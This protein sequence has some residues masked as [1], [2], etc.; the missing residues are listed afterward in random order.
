MKSN[1]RVDLSRILSDQV[2]KDF[3][4]RPCKKTYAGDFPR[5]PFLRAR[6]TFFSSKSWIEIMSFCTTGFRAWTGKNDDENPQKKCINIHWKSS[7]RARDPSRSGQFRQL[8]PGFPKHNYSGKCM[9]I[10]PADIDIFN[11][12]CGGLRSSGR[13]PPVRTWKILQTNAKDLPDIDSLT[14]LKKSL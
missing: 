13:I 8:F 14:G 4:T 12:D 7:S 3:Q 9:Y 2:T 10:H 11:D 1:N 6:Y 5:P